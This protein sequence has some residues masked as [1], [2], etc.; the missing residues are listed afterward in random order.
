VSTSEAQVFA[1]ALY[2]ALVGDALQSLKTAA[3][4]LATLPNDSAARAQ[5]LS[6]AVP[7]GAPREVQNFVQALANEGALDRLPSIVEAF[8]QYAA[9]DTRP[10]SGEVVSA[11]ELSEAQRNTI[12]NDL[13]GRYG[14]RLDLRFNVDPSL[15]G[16]LIIRIGDQVLDNSLRTRLSAIQRNMLAG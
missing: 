8:E 6:A 7:A 14:S 4:K 16:G 3:A 12:L 15:I 9:S 10:V 11:V 1:R 2:D 13:R 5:A